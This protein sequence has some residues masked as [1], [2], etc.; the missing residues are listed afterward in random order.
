VKSAVDEAKQNRARI[1][2]AAL[3]GLVELFVD[4]ELWE[5]KSR[6]GW[7]EPCQDYR[8]A[9]VLNGTVLMGLIDKKAVKNPEK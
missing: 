4:L 2:F 8:P 7:R 6:F 5:T 1:P 9:S 3:A